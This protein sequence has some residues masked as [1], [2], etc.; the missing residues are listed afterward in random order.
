MKNLI[1]LGA[2]LAHVQLLS[3]LARRPPSSTQITLIAP[4][5]GQLFAPMMPGFVA[6]HYA[7]DE[8][9]VPLETLIKRAD[10]RWLN[11]AVV[12]FDA[13]ARTVRLDN[14]STYSFDWLS[15]NTDLV[16]DRQQ[17]EAAMP[18]AREHCL[19][20]RPLASFAALW[21]RVAELGAGRALRIAVLGATREAI[22]LAL[23]VRQ[24]LPNAAV[25]LVADDPQITGQT[26]AAA[27]NRRVAILKQERITLLPD[28]TVRIEAEQ[29]LMASGVRLAC[30][31]PLLAIPGQ[32]PAWLAESGLGL[33]DNGFVALDAC[34]RSLSHPNVFAAGDRDGRADSALV[35]N[36][37][38]LV[39]GVSARPYAGSSSTMQFTAYGNRRALLE[40]GQFSAQGRWV[41]WLKDRLD[42]RYLQRYRVD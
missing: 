34:R 36:L 40:W 7:L 21:P 9:L 31:V 33:N 25:T 32:T 12:V 5:P 39:S 26:Q 42:R 11:R 41:G 20:L 29:I 1:L 23:A 16:Q 19:F 22:E 13:D 18:G 2:G 35:K 15:V 3:K 38:A 14:G 10:V 24:R 28:V 30:D 27:K 17:I 6:G 8:C 37:S 4:Y